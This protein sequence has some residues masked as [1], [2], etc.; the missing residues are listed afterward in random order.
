MFCLHVGSAVLRGLKE[1]RRFAKRFREKVCLCR[2]MGHPVG[3]A[4]TKWLICQGV[5]KY[6]PGLLCF[7]AVSLLG[8]LLTPSTFCGLPGTLSHLSP[9]PFCYFL[10]YSPIGYGCQPLFW[11]IPYFILAFQL[12]PVSYLF[13]VSSGY[14]PSYV[15][16][17]TVHR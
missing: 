8:F 7:T 14:I 4:S 2:S 9:S 6:L 17:T 13:Q 5:I 10:P 16:N 3:P 1:L 15:F 12:H 11:R